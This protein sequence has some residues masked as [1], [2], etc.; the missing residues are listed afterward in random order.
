MTAFPV[1]LDPWMEVAGLLHELFEQDGY[2]VARIGPTAIV[3]PELLSK[4]LADHIGRR[5]SVLRTDFDFRYRILED[6]V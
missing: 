1:R 2:Q 5:I 3:L 4:Q 6:S